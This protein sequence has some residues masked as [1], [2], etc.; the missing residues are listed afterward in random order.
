MTIRHLTPLLVAL[1]SL[2]AAACGGR[3][4]EAPPPQPVV[5]APANN[6]E[7]HWEGVARIATPIP[8]APQEMDIVAVISDEH[9]V[10]CGTIEYSSAACSGAW[11]CGANDGNS[12]S[13]QETIRYGMERCPS[14]ANI[15]LNTTN[16]P[17]VLD[18]TYSSPQIQA[19][20]TIHRRAV[21]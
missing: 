12:L 4:E 7:G 18:F 16:D 21:L 2:T 17:D 3:V 14:G 13:I 5:V 8:N 9:V 20:G 19:R 11:S 15:Q 10:Q 6:F 1:L